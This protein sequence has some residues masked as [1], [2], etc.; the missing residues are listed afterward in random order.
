MPWNIFS[1]EKSRKRAIAKCYKSFSGIVLKSF[2]RFST[3]LLID[4]GG[5][6][7]ACGIE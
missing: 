7:V 3:L 1:V 4:F 2:Y 5:K 6:D